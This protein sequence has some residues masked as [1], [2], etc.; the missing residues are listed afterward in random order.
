M[1]KLRSYLEANSLS[2]AAFAVRV[3]LNQ[4][5]I[6]KLCAGSMRPSL[7]TAARIAAATDGAVPYESW[8]GGQ[9]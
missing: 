4:A 8:I 7:E 5:T 2:Q 6:S 9:A 3:G 1:E